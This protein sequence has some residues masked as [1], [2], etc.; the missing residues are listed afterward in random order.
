MQNLYLIFSH[1]LTKTQ[2][3]EALHHWQIEEFV[4]L[5]QDL[6][7][8]WSNINPND[9][10]EVYNIKKITDWLLQSSQ[11]KDYILVQGEFGATFYM[12]D[13][14]FRNERI[15]IYSTTKRQAREIKTD[16]NRIEKVNIFE[17]VIYRKYRR[18]HG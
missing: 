8:I 11:K 6:Q 3:E 2:T 1:H 13:F 7:K 18:Y 17:H 4:Y 14:C 16:S 15:P 9:E 12:V 10:L 5:P